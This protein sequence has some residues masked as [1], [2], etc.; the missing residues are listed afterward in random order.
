MSTNGLERRALL[1]DRQAQEECT[2]QEIALPCP[3]CG[4]ENSRLVDAPDMW[5]RCMNCG[6]YGPEG[7][8]AKAAL[9]KW[10]RRPAPPIGRC[11][12]CI[13]Y[14]QSEC[15]KI[16]DDGACSEYARQERKPDDFC[17]YFEEAPHEQPALVR[18]AERRTSNQ[19]KPP[20]NTP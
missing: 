20:A 10:N 11:K 12:D 19:E 3:F 15:L 2:R 16:Y 18:H 8:G 13:H 9:A 6:A 7:N 1:G 4:A 14:F 17:N 5:Y